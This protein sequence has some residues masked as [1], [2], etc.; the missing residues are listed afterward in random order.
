MDEALKV[1]GTFILIFGGLFVIWLATDGPARFE[2]ENQG[3][4]ITPITAPTLEGGAGG[5]ETYGDL[6]KMRKY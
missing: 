2:R 3:L 4:F 1:L 5:G 6:P